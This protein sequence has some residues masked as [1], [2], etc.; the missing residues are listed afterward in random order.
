M[1]EHRVEQNVHEPTSEKKLDPI[2][3]TPSHMVVHIYAPA[4]FEK[5]DAM[6]SNKKCRKIAKRN[7]KH[8]GSCIVLEDSTLACRALF[9]RGLARTRSMT[10]RGV[11]RWI[12]QGGE[13]K[14]SK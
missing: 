2:V 11:Q 14:P 12:V 8:L 13:K 7:S 3:S 9:A 4:R 1:L 10:T 6:P 5:R